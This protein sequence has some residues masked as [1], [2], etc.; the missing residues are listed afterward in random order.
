MKKNLKLSK[1]EKKLNYMRSY[2]IAILRQKAF[3]KTSFFLQS[4]AYEFFCIAVIK[5]YF[6]QKVFGSC[7]RR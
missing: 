6:F 1:V 3:N 2:P 5:P 7:T 4:N